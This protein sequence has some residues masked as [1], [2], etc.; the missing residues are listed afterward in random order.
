MSRY[1]QRSL[2]W[3]A[4][5][6]SE[7]ASQLASGPAHTGLVP[8]TRRAEQDDLP[9]VAFAGWSWRAVLAWGGI[10]LGSAV[11]ASAFTYGVVGELDQ[12]RIPVS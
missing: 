7:V 6:I 12:V 3:G 5:G 1:L 10:V 9:D 11:P 8:A 4:A 2:G